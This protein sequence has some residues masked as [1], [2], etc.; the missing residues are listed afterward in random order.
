MKRK[1]LIIILS[2]IFIVSCLVLTACHEHEYNACHEHEYNW[3]VVCEPSCT[4]NGLTIG[5]CS[6]GEQTMSVVPQLGHNY[7]SVIVKPSCPNQGYTSHTCTICGDT[8]KDTYVKANEKHDFQKSNNCAYCKCSITDVA[9]K[10][11]DMSATTDDSVKCYVINRPGDYYFDAYIKGKGAIKNSAFRY[12]NPHDNGYSLVNVY[13]ENG[14]TSIGD[15]AFERCITLNSVTFEEGSHLTSIGDYAFELCSELT[16]ITIPSGVT[17]IG[18]QAFY[19]CESLTSV[20]FEEDSQLISIGNHA[21]Y[22][23]GSLTSITIPSSVTFIG[24][25]AFG[26]CD[27]LT[28]VTFEDPAVWCC[29]DKWGNTWGYN[30]TMTDPSKNATYLKDTYRQYWWYK[31]N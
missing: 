23:C 20:I 25:Y 11:Y 21:F 6:C 2:A 24:E 16:T 30:L 4:E 26:S 8:Y 28:S 1:M 18:E 22:N 3:N 10:V 27:S 17:S 13:I 31:S 19:Y 29:D 14:I 15:F 7:S 9:V 5:E 12:F